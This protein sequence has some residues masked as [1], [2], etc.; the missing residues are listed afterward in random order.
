MEC[1][2]YIVTALN[3]M[4]T[5]NLNVFCLKMS[6]TWKMLENCVLVNNLLQI[7]KISYWVKTIHIISEIYS[8]D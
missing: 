5:Y 8:N 7:H 6:A 1:T 2:V 4:L 3:S